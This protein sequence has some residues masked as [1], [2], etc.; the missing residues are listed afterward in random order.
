MQHFEDRTS[1]RGHNAI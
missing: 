1:V